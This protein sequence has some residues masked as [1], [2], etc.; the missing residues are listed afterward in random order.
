MSIVNSSTNI[1]K[2]EQSPQS[3]EHKKTMRYGIG[4]PSP[5]LE[6]AQEGGGVKLVSLLPNISMMKPCY[7]FQEIFK[8]SDFLDISSLYC[9]DIHAMA[10]RYGIEAAGRVII[11]VIQM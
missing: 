8:Y 3:L 6:Q 7:I 2:N 4:N 10:E 11:K 5:G 1:N 9:N